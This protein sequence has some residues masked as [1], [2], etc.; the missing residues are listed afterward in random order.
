MNSIAASLFAFTCAAALLT[1]T[2]GLDTALVLR[3]V[4]SEGPRRAL[5]CGIGIVTGC[6]IWAI[7]V[8][9][10]LSG[11]LLASEVA[12]DALR[13]CGAAYLLYV[14]FKLVFKPR[15]GFVRDNLHTRGNG[16]VRGA[17][18]NLLNPKVG[19]FYVSFLPLFIP[20]G[21]SIAAFILLLGA[22]H[23]LLGFF[24]FLTLITAARPLGQWLRR[25]MVVR[26]LD[27]LTGGVF[28]AF[29]TRLAMSMDRD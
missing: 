3:T 21:V 12:Y 20:S 5:W 7:I 11:L 23:A 27:R 8:A 19:I 24:W 15:D 16:F 25:P 14:G 2:P 17:L 10:G 1:I 9:A 29:G 18:T 13:L 26:L 22:V 4:V 28:I 6:F